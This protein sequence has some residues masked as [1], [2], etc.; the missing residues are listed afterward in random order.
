MSG[1]AL[2]VAAALILVL[3]PELAWYRAERRLRTLTLA[4]R[5]L[6]APGRERDHVL[7]AV[8]DGA[9][10][11]AAV[12]RHDARALMLAGSARLVARDAPGALA[13]YRAALACG[14]R[15][16]I[17]LALARAHIQARDFTAG[18]AAL[19]RAGWVSPALV[20]TL[21][22]A[23]RRPLLREIKLLARALRAGRLTTP[24]L[25]A[26]ADEAERAR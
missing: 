13:R 14:E 9:R 16:E 10:A 19:V 23:G 5:A 24:P 18:Q 11:V 21:P 3:W 26:P 7:A 1:R 25:L 12:Q 2:A 22:P 4:F 8:D 6:P 17:D 15:A 20:H